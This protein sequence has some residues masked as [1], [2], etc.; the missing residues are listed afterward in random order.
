MLTGVWVEGNFEIS[1]GHELV[2]DNL[3][4]TA[5][6][7]FVA[8]CFCWPGLPSVESKNRSKTTEKAS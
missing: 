1:K 8:R 6:M 2:S 7:N 3:D 4:L 5:A